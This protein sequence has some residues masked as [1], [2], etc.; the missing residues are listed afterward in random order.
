[1][2]L[3]KLQL[4][5]LLALGGWL[6]SSCASGGDSCGNFI[7]EADETSVTCPVDCG[8]VTCPNGVCDIGENAV[9]CELDCSGGI[10]GNAL[11][12]ASENTVTCPVDCV[13][14]NNTCDTGESAATC[15][16]D[17]GGGTCGNGICEATETATNCPADCSVNPE[18][19]DGVCNG[20]ETAATCPDDCGGSVCG[21]GTCD[22]D[23]DAATC[24]ADCGCTDPI[25]DLYPQCGCTGGQKC[26]LDTANN[27]ACLSAGTTQPGGI[28]TV[29][30]S[31]A[32]G[33]I[34]LGRNN[35]GTQ[36]QCLAYC[37][38]TTQAGCTGTTSYCQELVD[39]GSVPIPGAG[40]CTLTCQPHNP[41]SGCPAGYT[42]EIYTHPVTDVSFTDC[43]ADV[44]TGTYD[45]SCDPA[46][47]PYCS[48]GYGCFTSGS[49]P[50]SS[51]F[52]WCTTG[53]TC[54]FGSC[55]TAAFNPTL[56]LA[57]TTYGI[58]R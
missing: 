35:D 37:D 42:C 52:Q 8:G 47:G 3:R 51:C 6:A 17:C 46:N 15:P 36:G 53:S 50:T 18:C 22:A 40:I 24:P 4:L 13:C 57:G 28:C 29:D 20:T 9:N 34:C 56:V 27:R 19:G 25:C 30:T 41:T 58:C 43:H 48:A 31:C 12:E 2:L 1:M 33:S 26:S 10:C 32:A 21:D 5:G 49:P 44:G 45:D 7:C 39:S 23:E 14:G 11:C 54:A 55:D 38:P 16:Q